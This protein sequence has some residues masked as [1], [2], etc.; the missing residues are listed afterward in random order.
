LRTVREVLLAL[1]F[2]TA[3]FGLHSVSHLFARNPIADPRE[4]I[5]VAARL[6]EVELSLD[7]YAVQRGE[8]PP[9]LDEL[10]EDRWIS[11]AH[12]DLPGYLI[13]YQRDPSGRRYDLELVPRP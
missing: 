10:V 3:V 8:Y 1:A 6:R 13:R 9:H 4:D 2:G 12:L 5:F 7:L 11:A